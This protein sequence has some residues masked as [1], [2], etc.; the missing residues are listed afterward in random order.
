MG[1]NEMKWCGTEWKK[2]N[3]MNYNNIFVLK[4]IITLLF[5]FYSYSKKI[6]M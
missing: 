2:Q 3:E 6:I 5:Y 1:E 4:W